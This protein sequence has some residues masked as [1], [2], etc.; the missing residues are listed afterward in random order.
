MRNIFLIRTTPIVL[1]RG[2][3]NSFCLTCDKHSLVFI[4]FRG[5]HHNKK[6]LAPFTKVDDS[7]RII[8]QEIRIAFFCLENIC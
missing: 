6:I 4:T 2:K 1:K 5:T 7:L 3:D 8:G